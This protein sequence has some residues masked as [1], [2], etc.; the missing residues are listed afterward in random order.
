MSLNFFKGHPTDSLL[1]TEAVLKASQSLLTRTRPEDSC[2]DDRHPLT[3]GSD[4]GSLT[5]RKRLASWSAPAFH[6]TKDSVSAAVKSSL[7]LS[8]LSSIL[9][10]P[11]NPNSIN[12]TNGASYGAM[13]AL[14]Q[15]TLPHGGPAAP[16][17]RAFIVSP[18]YFLI[19]SVF[20]DAGFAGKLTA[21]KQDA[22]TGA[23][24]WDLL[25]SEL[26]RYSKQPI[27]NDNNN[28]N[29]NT[30]TQN[31]SPDSTTGD[32]SRPVPRKVYQFVI[33]LVPTFSNPTGCTMS[34]PDR[35]RL[36]ALARKYDML[37]LCDDVYDL[38]PFDSSADIPPR[39]VTL[40]R[41]TLPQSDDDTALGNT[42]SNLTFSKLL[43]PG[44]R[45]GWQETPTPALAQNHLATGGAVRSGGTPAHFA[46]MIV[47]E[48][49]RLNL[50]D[51]II[52]NLRKIYGSRATALKKAVATHFSLDNSTSRPQARL[53]GADGGYFA[54]LELIPTPEY[55]R[56]GLDASK[57][58]AAC[59]AHSNVVVAPG[60]AF[61]VSGQ[62]LG[63][64]KNC[65][66]ISVSY[67]SESQ[68]EKGIEAFASIVAKLL[69]GDIK[70]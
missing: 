6:E 22:S 53:Y 38:L 4:P 57:I 65:F 34:L 67:L 11:I 52:S 19:N 18:T 42:I 39:I 23:L 54:W 27:N 49:L 13:N 51:P 24:D 62:D 70:V 28:N 48:L 41:W 36:L 33:Y 25:E 3:Y 14:L 31:L 16:T 66:R 1:P 59:S 35:L 40:D 17:R 9:S 20:L 12:L 69:T 61:E 15:L 30:C 50:V 29:N 7:E 46:T 37:I 45:V 8:K 47:G 10:N 56:L 43:G 2:E 68:I 5:V 55:T 44:L 63:W 64:N 60:G 58:A 26:E 32:D 21:I